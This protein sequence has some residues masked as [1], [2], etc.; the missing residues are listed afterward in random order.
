MASFKLAVTYT[1]I[2]SLLFPILT[3]VINISPDQLQGFWMYTSEAT[4]QAART[5]MRIEGNEIEFFLDSYYSSGFDQ[6]F[7]GEFKII[8]NSLLI[9]V[10]EYYTL[11]K[12]TGRLVKYKNCPEHQV[13]RLRITNV[14]E[15]K[16]Q[17]EII[18]GSSLL[19]LISFFDSTKL[20]F[21][22]NTN[23]YS[24]IMEALLE[25]KGEKTA[26]L[27]YNI[28]DCNTAKEK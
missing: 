14:S 19:E 16:I 12:N 20:S 7:K 25:H 3:S 4:D 26:D 10:E 6:Y 23:I 21:Y 5:Q 11:S 17:L 15:S 2:L 13:Q 27:T 8:Q 1:Y 9:H 24:P 18:P 28:V 22:R